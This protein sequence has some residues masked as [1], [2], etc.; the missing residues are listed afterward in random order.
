MLFAEVF[1]EIIVPLLV[2]AVA[3]H[4]GVLFRRCGGGL[5]GFLIQHDVQGELAAAADRGDGGAVAGF[6][7]PK[8]A[9]QFRDI[10]YLCASQVDDDILHLD[11]SPVGAVALLHAD[12]VSSGGQAEHRSGFRVGVLYGDAQISAG[13]ITVVDQI[14][15]PLQHLLRNSA[16]HGIESPEERKKAAEDK[17]TEAEAATEAGAHSPAGFLIRYTGMGNGS[18]M[19]KQPMHSVLKTCV[20]LE[21]CQI[22]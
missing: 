12:N 9:G 1:P 7:I 10:G 11:A 16:D 8:G 17:P 22:S 19:K 6:E 21:S 5:L 14:G 18:M 13:D 20:P 15:D 2:I 4:F 3:G